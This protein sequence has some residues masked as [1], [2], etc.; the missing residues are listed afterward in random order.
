VGAV[1]AEL[2]RLIPLFPLPNALLFPRMPLPLHVFEPRY[3]KMVADA[4]VSHR[5]IGISL[6]RAGWE[7]DY[8]GRPPI[9]PIGCAGTMERCDPLVDGRF[10]IVLRGVSRFRVVEEHEGEPYRVASVEALDDPTGELAELEAARRKV[11]AAIGEAV[12]GPAMLVSQPGL[13]HDVFVNALC[14][15]LSLSP[16]EQQSLLDCDT[17]LGR[18][19]RLLEILDFRLMERTHGRGGQGLH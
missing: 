11:F 2:P 4:M 16:L 6:L 14:Q 10:N 13:S 18:C 5:T 12:D 9:Y 3:R 15:S 1:V 17:I 8:E 7:K 19:T